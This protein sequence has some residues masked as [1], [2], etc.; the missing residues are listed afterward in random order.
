MSQNKKSKGQ[1]FDTVIIGA[2]LSGLTIG[3]AIL[4][5][6]SASPLR[7]A[8]VEASESTG[9]SSR[10][11]ITPIGELD[12]G[13]KIF[14]ET[15]ATHEALDWLEAILDQKIERTLVEAQPLNYD[16]GKFKPY[17]G[18]GDNQIFS[19]TEIEAYAAPQRL[20]LS[21]TP[22]DWVKTLSER[23]SDV[24][25]TQSYVTKLELEDGNI[26]SVTIN[27]TTQLLTKNVVYT[28]SPHLLV[29]LLPEGTLMAKMRQ[30]LVK[31]DFWTSVNLD[32]IHSEPVTDSQAIHVLRGANEEPTVGMFLNPVK[33]DSGEILQASQW[34][35][36]IPR[37]QIDEEELVASALKQIKRQIKRAYETGLDGIRQER[38]LVI[39]GSHGNLSQALDN[40]AQPDDSGHCFIKLPKIAN[41]WLSSS[42]F[43]DQRNTVGT[44]LQAKA[45][46]FGLL[47]EVMV[48]INADSGSRADADRATSDI[49]IAVGS[50]SGARGSTGTN[51]VEQEADEIAPQTI[52]RPHDISP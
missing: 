48:N 4:A 1:V 3:A 20:Q 44:L 18:F 11:G 26:V 52:D 32:L 33:L 10:P 19:T 28:A 37:D 43:S 41:L 6:R 34:M 2:G 50:G 51:I 36:L 25:M 17:V 31:G 14:P 27:G 7:I 47:Q 46:S 12:H 39:P 24:I 5:A 22:K 13:L 8:I 29:P 15:P 42:F 23:L 40:L 9:G 30:K 38:I 16:E 21:S 45:Q 49:A 35:T